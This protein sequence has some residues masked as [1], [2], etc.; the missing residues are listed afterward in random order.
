MPKRRKSKNRGASR[1][2]TRRI[3]VSTLVG[4][5]TLVTAWYTLPPELI[6]EDVVNKSAEFSSESRIKITNHGLLSAL[7]IRALTENVSARIGTMTILGTDMLAGP[8]VIRKLTH[9]ESQEITIIPNIGIPPGT[10]VSSCSY[11]LILKYK[12]NLCSIGRLSITKNWRKKWNVVL[13]KFPDGYDWQI[14]I[15]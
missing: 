2:R 14:S 1:R 6:I 9:N 15:L 3:Q 7:S 5:L 13:H 4:I 10:H 11:I 8:I 12:I